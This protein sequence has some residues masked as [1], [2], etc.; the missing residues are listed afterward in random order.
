MDWDWFRWIVRRHFSGPHSRYELLACDR[1]APAH[2]PDRL[3]LYLHVPFCRSFCPHCPY[4]KEPYEPRASGRFVAAVRREARQWAQLAGSSKLGSLYVGGGTPTLLGEQLGELIAALRTTFGGLE[5]V[6]VELLP[7]DASEAQL[8]MLARAGVNMISLGVQSFDPASLKIIGRPYRSEV[9]DGAIARTVSGGFDFVNL[10]MMFVLPGQTLADLRRDI[11]KALAGGADQL[12]FYPLF[13]F[14]YTAVGKLRRQRRL[15]MPPLRQRRAQYRFLHDA[16]QQAGMQRVSVWGFAKPHRGKYSSVTRQGYIG[17][18]P[19]AASCLPGQYLFNTF[20]VDHYCQRIEAGRFA[21]ALGM[22]MTDD[23][24]RYY[25]LYWKLYETRVPQ[26]ELEK[27]FA[28]D[29]RAFRWL[30]RARHVGLIQRQ[31]G[32]L[33]L[34]ER[35]AFWVHW[36]QNKFVLH[37]IDTVWQRAMAEPFPARIAF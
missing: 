21:T 12:T 2:W 17:L 4:Y 7:T 8:D 36:L 34:T 15:R 35:G 20:S 37:Y 18:G 11:D 32:E 23:M 10:D 16:M 9:L 28:R 27:L 31:D 25:W 14:P 22:A 30:R 29:H 13:T 33:T 3:D 26:A 5:Q 6:A 19:G 1:P 24:Q